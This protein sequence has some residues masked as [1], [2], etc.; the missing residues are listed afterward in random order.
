MQITKS[1]FH[2]ASSWL[3]CVFT[4]CEGGRPRILSTGNK[5]DFTMAHSRNVMIASLLLGVALTSAVQA[6]SLVGL[7]GDRTITTF[8]S[9]TLKSGKA[10]TIKGVNGRVA[11]IDMR[12][13][14]GQLYAVTMDGSVYTVNPA[15]GVATLKVKLEKML[16]ADA[17]HTIDFN[18]AADRLRLIGSDGT[19]LRANVDDGK[20]TVDGSLKYADSDPAAGKKPNV[21]AGA[22][23]NSVKGTKETALYDIDAALGTFLKQAPPN[24]GILGTIGKTGIKA[25]SI[26]F[27]IGT[28]AAGKNTGYAVTGV[29]LYTLDIATGVASRLGKLKGLPGSLRDIAVIAR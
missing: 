28:D 16:P 1:Y 7:S 11:G 10:T 14:D 27:D 6:E 8:D 20:V 17:V 12:P 21:V 5:G 26:A 23:S 22:Y 24:D 25:K 19:S 29:T 13:S 9:A 2:D 4:E 15:T 18:P 3:G